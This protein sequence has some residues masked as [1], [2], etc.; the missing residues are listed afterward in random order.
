MNVKNRVLYF[1][2]LA[3]MSI[4]VFGCKSKKMV[5]NDGAEVSG[6]H[7]KEVE[8]AVEG[9]TVTKTDKGMVLT[10][11]SDVL[12]D[13]NSSYLSD[14]AKSTLA[15]M[16]AYI[17]RNYPDSKL[18]IDGHTDATGTPEYN[19]ELSERRAKRVKDYLVERGLKAASISTKGYGLT[20][21]VAPNN[22]SEGRQKN[23]RVEI[24]I[25]K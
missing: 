25:L 17:K 19:M 23:R 16:V 7:V 14:N 1:V 20:K 21:P 24:T 13:I 2:V 15:N 18:Q 8:A 10:F 12:F 6:E 4:A 11:Q 9:S 5:V 3:W 22:T